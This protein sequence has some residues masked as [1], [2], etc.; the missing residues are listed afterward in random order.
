[1]AQTRT[2]N[3]QEA[4]GIATVVMILAGLPVTLWAW[5]HHR[6]HD[7]SGAK[8]IALTAVSDP[9]IWTRDDIAGWNYWWRTP[10]PVDDIPMQQGDTVL[11]QLRSV[12]VLH[13]FAIP[14][15]H[16][17]P[18]EVPSGH[19]VEVRFKADRAG[20]LMFLCWQVCSPQH[21]NLH[22]R[23]VVQGSSKDQDS[24]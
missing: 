6:M 11:L 14:L 16:V 20:A 19:T 21:Q 17:G 1:M 13:S 9:G 3:W 7:A 2:H 15:L 22:G 5:R 23:F 18:V 4:L 12:D 10:R 8:V 24:W